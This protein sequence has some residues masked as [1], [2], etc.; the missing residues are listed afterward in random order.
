MKK[1]F[2]LD[3]WL[4][5]PDLD[6][7][8]KGSLVRRLRPQ[9]MDLLAYLASRP[10]EIVSNEEI[11]SAVWPG[12]VTTQASVYNCLKD[13]RH[14]LDD[15]P[16]EP[17][18][19]ETIPK[20]GYR[21]IA[22]VKP[23]E[24][25]SG[26]GRKIPGRFTGRQLAITAAAIVLAAVILVDRMVYREPV[27]DATTPDV[28]EKSIAVL[29][30]MDLS[31]GGDQAYF[32]DGIAE[33]IL[34]EL[35]QSHDLKVTARGSSFAFRDSDEDLRSIGE[36]LGVA[37]V[38]EGSVRKDA[39]RVR[40]TA[41]LVDTRNGFHLWSEEYDR[42]AGTILNIQDAIGTEVANALHV[43]LSRSDTSPEAMLGAEELDPRVYDL[44]LK[45][46]NLI[47]HGR[48]DSL[49]EATTLL[50]EILEVDPD[51]HR[52]RILLIDS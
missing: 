2:Y 28:P 52:A 36:K 27:E 10:R 35:A 21:L 49:T 15:D 3:D 44:F 9:V 30:F 5:E 1:A 7:I 45:A 24:R 37:Y 41:Q 17:T 26:D 32:A 34:D 33:E 29:P 51:F 50:Y 19:I 38:L 18:Y 48:K 6:R 14:G 11:L 4:V 47:N 46:K 31:P 20:R 8:R 25:P 43:T 22:R 40:I 13:L 12:R 39:N 16:H 23:V 42:E